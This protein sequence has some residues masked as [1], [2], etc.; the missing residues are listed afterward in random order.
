MGSTPGLAGTD[1]SYHLPHLDE[2]TTHEQPMRSRNVAYRAVEGSGGSEH[3]PKVGHAPPMRTRHRRHLMA[4]LGALRLGVAAPVGPPNMLAEVVAQAAVVVAGHPPHH[5]PG[6]TH[7]G[8]RSQQV[9][10]QRGPAAAVAADQD[11]ALGHAL[12]CTAP[13]THATRSSWL[14]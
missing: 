7:I 2:S 4:A 6:G 10:E 13:T 12:A 14:V 1:R 9:G 11:R 5:L 3:S 8:M